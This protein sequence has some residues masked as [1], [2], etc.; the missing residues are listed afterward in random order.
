MMGGVG[1]MFNQSA[2]GLGGL[3]VSTS[4]A[5]GGGLGGLSQSGGMM[6]GAGKPGFFSNVGTSLGGMGMGMNQVGGHAHVTT[7]T[8]RYC[9]T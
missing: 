6:G 5:L 7:C 2:G 4:T 3:G 9:D 1:G 8:Y